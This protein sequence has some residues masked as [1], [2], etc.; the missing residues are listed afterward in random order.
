[1]NNIIDDDTIKKIDEIYDKTEEL[2]VIFDKKCLQVK[3]L[4]RVILL[5]M[6]IILWEIMS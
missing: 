5:L 6:L 4:R 2:Q 3:F 1:M